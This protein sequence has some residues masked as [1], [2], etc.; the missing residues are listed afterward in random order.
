MHLQIDNPC[1]KDVKQNKRERISFINIYDIS[2]E[3]FIEKYESEYE[4]DL[5]G[6]YVISVEDSFCEKK[7]FPSKYHIKILGLY[8]PR[9]DHKAKLSYHGHISFI[10]VKEKENDNTVAILAKD[11]ECFP[12]SF[13]DWYDEGLQAWSYMYESSE[14]PTKIDIVNL[15]KMLIRADSQNPDLKIDIEF[16]DIIVLQGL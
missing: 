10:T 3:A 11:D 8:T 6:K 5:E 14:I 12:Q 16:D 13:N 15:I 7:D 9:T 1:L 4:C 2:P